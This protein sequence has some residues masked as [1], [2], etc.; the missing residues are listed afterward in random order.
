MSRVKLLSL[1]AVFLGVAAA[2]C[3]APTPQDLQAADA[4][5]QQAERAIQAL[6]R[7]VVDKDPALITPF[8]SP[9]LSPRDVS[10]L[11]SR[12]EQASWLERYSG[13]T[14][15][16]V[17]ALGG[18]SWRDWRRPEVCLAVPVVAAYGQTSED[19]LTLEKVEDEWLI[20][21]LQMAEP[22]PG[23]LLDPPAAVR[24]AIEPQARELMA[25]LEGG[26]YSSVMYALPK[27]QASRFRP[28]VLSWWER[29]IGSSVAG[30]SVLS[31]LETMQEFSILAWPD[32]QAVP[33][34]VYDSPNVI[35]V[36]YEVPYVWLRGGVSETDVLRMKLLYRKTPDGWTFFS[37]RL[38]GKAIPSS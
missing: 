16:L 36:L 6:A 20:K 26:H 14:P 3:A 33:Q 10:L 13:Y 17:E 15:D 38:S 5:R 18:T 9:R 34:L 22:R 32:L 8:L 24:R 31:D 35:A 12:L 11:Q 23:D 29:L 25:D 1:G 28:P 7:A 27:D 21:G 30:I 19:E 2:G 4:G 37:I